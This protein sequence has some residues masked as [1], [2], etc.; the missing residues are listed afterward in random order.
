METSCHSCPSL[1]TFTLPERCMLMTRAVHLSANG[2]EMLK[3]RDFAF[4]KRYRITPIDHL[5][6]LHTESEDEC[7]PGSVEVVA[8]VDWRDA[9]TLITRS[10][11]RLT[12]CELPAFPRMASTLH[13]GHPSL[14]LSAYQALGHAARFAC[15]GKKILTMRSPRSS[16]R[17][18]KCHER[19]AIRQMSS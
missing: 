2:D 1:L 18:K 19:E 4:L 13:H 6:V 3:I 15:A 12:R 11:G 5:L 14:V 16:F 8:P 10:E 17:S 7:T 9:N